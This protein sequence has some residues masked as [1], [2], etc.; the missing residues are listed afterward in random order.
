MNKLNFTLCFIAMFATRLPAMDKNDLDESSFELMNV[1]NYNET[2]MNIFLL[3]ECK[4]IFDLS[5]DSFSDANP[6]Q[7]EVLKNL[8]LS[9]KN[10]LLATILDKVGNEDYPNIRGAVACLISAGASVNQLGHVAKDNALER[11]VLAQ[12]KQMVEL[13]LQHNADPNQNLGYGPTFFSAKKLS[14]AELFCQYGAAFHERPDVLHHV[15]ST[16]DYKPELLTFYLKHGVDVNCTDFK[17]LTPLEQLAVCTSRY[18]FEQ[19]N[20]LQKAQILNEAGTLESTKK[21]V[22]QKLS[23]STATPDKLIKSYLEKKLTDTK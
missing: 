3:S 15:V 2:D 13:L 1:A 20:L 6:K 22:I 21:D 14:M 4:N 17:G 16:P 5:D 19:T 11:A 23:K 12:D 9:E 7:W 8:P 10:Y 18:R